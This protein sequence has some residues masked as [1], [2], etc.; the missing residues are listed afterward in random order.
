MMKTNVKQTRN[1]VYET[2][3]PKH[4]LAH[5]VGTLYGNI[6]PIFSELPQIEKFIRYL[7]HMGLVERKSVFGGFANNTG[8]D[9]PVHPR[10]L[11]SAFVIPFVES[12]ICKHATSEISIFLASL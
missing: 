10:S 8:V 7:A 3:S 4:M 11:I 12:I 2:L 1:S 9:Q 5:K 6:S